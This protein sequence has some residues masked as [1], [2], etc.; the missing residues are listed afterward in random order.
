M[1]LSKQAVQDCRIPVA[2]VMRE[3]VPD[4]AAVSFLERFLFYFADKGK[5][6]FIAFQEAVL[7]MRGSDQHPG[8]RWLPAVY[9]GSLTEPPTW[10]QL[11]GKAPKPPL[12]SIPKWVA[13]S[14]VG[15]VAAI[16]A[17]A[18][19]S[20][21]VPFL[22]DSTVN[23]SPSPTSSQTP[24]PDT[25]ISGGGQVLIDGETLSKEKIATI[26]EKENCIKQK[27]VDVITCFEALRATRKADPEVLTYLNNLRAKQNAESSQSPLYTIAVAAPLN[28]D[29]GNDILRGV[30][31]V[32]N[33][34]L[35]IKL[36][37]L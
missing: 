21:R 32:Q 7:A 29:A 27:S 4:T 37:Y 25:L 22:P 5:P 3:P 31:Q 35:K 12:P 6:L 34:R 36:I 15:G 26:G 9:G 30:A 28:Q 19:H 23:S 24:S 10:K 18:T 20:I 33:K 16:I 13:L 17:I 11:G 2:I 14:T 1:G 8:V